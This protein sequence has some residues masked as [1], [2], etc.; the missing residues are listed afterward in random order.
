[1]DRLAAW[2]VRRD[3]VATRLDRRSRGFVWPLA[4]LLVL[5][6]TA[7]VQSR[8]GA[9]PLGVQFDARRQ[10]VAAV[11]HLKAH[12]PAGHGFNYLAWGGYLVH[13]L[14][15]AQPIFIDGQMDV[16][17]ESLFRDYNQ[18]TTLEPGWQDVLE[19]HQVD[20]VIY[21]TESALVRQLAETGWSVSFRDATATVLVRRAQS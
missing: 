1:V 13:E 15:P 20:W 3:Q 9:A 11:A 17:D 16:Y 18:V 6:L 7:V 14:W 10:P 8:A 5:S 12:P 4:A 2:V 21:P 19:R